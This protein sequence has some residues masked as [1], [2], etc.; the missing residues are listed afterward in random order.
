MTKFGLDMVAPECNDD[1]LLRDG[2]G[3]SKYVG[4]TAIPNPEPRT[5]YDVI[6]LCRFRGRMFL[7]GH[8]QIGSDQSLK[9]VKITERSKPSCRFFTSNYT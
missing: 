1:P 8:V 5:K 3:G 7:G 4:E 2:P 6:P 9:V